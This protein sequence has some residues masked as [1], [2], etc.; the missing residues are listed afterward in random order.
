LK[1]SRKTNWSRRQ[2]HFA[3]PPD[4]S[5]GGKPASARFLGF[6]PPTM[7]AKFAR[8]EVDAEGICAHGGAAGGV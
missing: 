5:A 6:F 1:T 2:L 7:G 4:V 8:H 3:R